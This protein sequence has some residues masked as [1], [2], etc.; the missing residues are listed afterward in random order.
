MG[1]NKDVTSEA[2]KTGNSA[3]TKEGKLEA[4]TNLLN[5]I[6]HTEN[7]HDFKEVYELLKQN[8]EWIQT[9][10]YINSKF[11][12]LRKY[13]VLLSCNTE[14]GIHVDELEESVSDMQYLFGS[15]CFLTGLRK[16]LL[17][18]QWASDEIKI[19]PRDIVL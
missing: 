10:G 19:N 4:A 6:V 17:L 1:E 12:E 13:I 8:D 9:K 16:G 18:K 14:K 2:L 15:A 3:A 7:E 5:M 11:E